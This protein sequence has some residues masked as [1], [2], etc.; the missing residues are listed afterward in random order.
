MPTGGTIAL[1]T[2]LSVAGVVVYLVIHTRM[3]GRGAT[4]GRGEVGYRVVDAGTLE[5][6]GTGR[7]VARYVASILATRAAV[8]PRPGPA[9]LILITK[10]AITNKLDIVSA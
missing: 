2:V 8:L 7:A 5:P 1:A 4:R 6:I 10:I 3:L 9:S